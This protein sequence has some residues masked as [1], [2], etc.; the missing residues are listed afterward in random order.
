MTEGSSRK[1]D[2]GGTGSCFVSV[3][4]PIA[5][6]CRM[7]ISYL[8]RRR[9]PSIAAPIV[10]I[11]LVPPQRQRSQ[12]TATSG[13][14]MSSQLPMTAA[15]VHSRYPPFTSAAFTSD[16]VTVTLPFFR[17]T[18]SVGLT[19]HYRDARKCELDM[20]GLRPMS[21]TRR[22]AI[23]LRCVTFPPQTWRRLQG[24]AIFLPASRGRDQ[25][26]TQQGWS[27]ARLRNSIASG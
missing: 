20:I 26:T 5:S 4:I 27:A 23:R 18:F 16:R 2:S 19:D 14:V 8:S 22:I 10:W 24:A 13:L 21:S 15:P 9:L 17:H 1:R 7:S 6:C 3:Y 11:A 12:P 25:P